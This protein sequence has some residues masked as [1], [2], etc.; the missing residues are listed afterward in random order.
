MCGIAGFIQRTPNPE[1]L[2]R[3][4]ARLVHRGP[5]GE[6]IWDRQ[7]DGWQVAIGHRRLSIIDVEGSPQPMAS[8]AD[9]VVL[10]YNGEIYNFKRLR[11]V[12]EARGRQF[13]TRG[14]TE[15]ILQQFQQHGVGGIPALEGMF[16]FAVWEGRTRRLTLARDRTGIKPLYYAE[17]ADG[18]IAFASELSALLAHGGIEPTL[19]TEGLEI[20]RASC[21]ER[22]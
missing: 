3:M 12:L 8:P 20:G 22:V 2:P 9:D 11:A 21:R 19:S 13:R 10:T 4:L 5:D 14:D 16:A 7:I 1:A 18:G 6:G 15:V 17:L